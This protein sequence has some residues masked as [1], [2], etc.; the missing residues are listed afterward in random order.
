MLIKVT[1][2]LDVPQSV[3]EEIVG[4]DDDSD[5]Y[6]QTACEQMEEAVKDDPDMVG[7]YATGEPDVEAT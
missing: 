4:V 1:Y 2:T 6:Y 5:T 3:I 7:K